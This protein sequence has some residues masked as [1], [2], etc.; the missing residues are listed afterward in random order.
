MKN[1]LAKVL[2]LEEYNEE[3]NIRVEPTEDEIIQIEQDNFVQ[4]MADHSEA[5]TEAL[6]AIGNA[7]ELASV[8]ARNDSQDKTAYEL[9]KVAVEQLKEKTG[10]YTQSVSLESLDKGSYKT[11][12]LEDVKKFISKVWEAIKKA[13]F[14]MWEK[15]KNFVK[16][17]FGNNK[18]AKESLDAAKA[19]N[20][21][22][23]KK[24]KETPKQPSANTDQVV[25]PNHLKQPHR[26]EPG[27][28]VVWGIGTRQAGNFKP[29]YLASKLDSQYSQLS[30]LVDKI[31]ELDVTKIVNDFKNKL[32]D[33]Y[34]NESGSSAPKIADYFSSV[35]KEDEEERIGGEVGGAFTYGTNIGTT[36]DRRYV[37]PLNPLKLDDLVYGK[38]Q[39]YYDLSNKLKEYAE[40]IAEDKIK[41]FFN[42]QKKE[43]DSM[44]PNTEQ[45]KK[46][47]EVIQQ[48]LAGFQS[49][50]S[51]LMTLIWSLDRFVVSFLT[52]FS[53]FSEENNK[54]FQSMIDEYEKAGKEIKSVDFDNYIDQFKYE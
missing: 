22:L 28:R 16:S 15:V 26:F 44:N 30:A 54:F 32:D 5:T 13:F 11:E 9:L 48:T 14:A 18:K 43:Y 37:R 12:A 46:Q 25:T 2:G 7:Q 3:P 40:S 45:S 29:E 20:D 8:I 33:Y 39:K 23:I 1:N 36:M 51:K 41:D 17:L 34:V 38:L 31:T 35:F 50:L 10:V 49:A 47:I 6:E 42:T 53:S 52:N 27:D 19:Q 24:A 21:E 4:D